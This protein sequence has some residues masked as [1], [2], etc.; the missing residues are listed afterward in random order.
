MRCVVV[1]TFHSP[2]L[3]TQANLERQSKKVSSHG[4]RLEKQAH[5]EGRTRWAKPAFVRFGS[6]NDQNK[7]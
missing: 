1:F 6:P 5:T 3:A 7:F 2:C 4:H